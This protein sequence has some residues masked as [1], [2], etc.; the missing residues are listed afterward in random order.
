MR[1]GCFVYWRIDYWRLASCSLIVSLTI[2]INAQ[3]AGTIEYTDCI[4]A[5]E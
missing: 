4:S 3:S 2:A 5:E 1:L